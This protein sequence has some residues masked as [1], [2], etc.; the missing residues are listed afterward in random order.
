[1]NMNK[2]KNNNIVCDSV[3]YDEKRIV[4]EWLMAAKE[5]E[6]DREEKDLCDDVVICFKVRFVY[7]DDEMVKEKERGRLVYKDKFW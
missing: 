1:M 2:N 3:E 6:R 5:R 7:K 4:T